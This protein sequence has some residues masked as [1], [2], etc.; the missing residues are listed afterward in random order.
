MPDGSHRIQTAS[1]Q[2]LLSS[3]VSKKKAHRH[4]LEERMAKR[5]I[6]VDHAAVH[7]WV[8]RYS[9]ELLERLNSR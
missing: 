5:G 7:R 3:H 6:S 8:I 4:P 9:P 2:A 1:D